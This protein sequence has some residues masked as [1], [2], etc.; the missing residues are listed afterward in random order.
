MYENLYRDLESG[1]WAE[2]NPFTCECRGGWL[3]SD[4]DTWHRCP[5]HGV[6]VPHPE[7]EHTKFDREAHR[8]NLARKAYVTFREV[9]RRNGFRGSFKAACLAEAGVPRPSVKEWVN[10]AEA[11]AERLVYEKAEVA[12]RRAGYSCALEQRWAVEAACE[13]GGW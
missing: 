13:R 2:V 9:A 5:I 10:A 4:L 12:A 11:V 8:L 7:D 1:C 3:L 6:G